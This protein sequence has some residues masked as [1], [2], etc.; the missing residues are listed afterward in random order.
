[1]TFLEGAYI[2]LRERGEYMEVGDIIKE[3]E[4][5]PGFFRSRAAN[6]YNS[7]Y[8]TLIKAVQSGDTRFE[9]LKDGPYFRATPSLPR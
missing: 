2:V 4:R 8:G 3:T 9:R 7:L 5:R 1:M 6:K